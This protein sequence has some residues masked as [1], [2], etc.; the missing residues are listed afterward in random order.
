MV[1]G[2]RWGAWAAGAKG[3]GGLDRPAAARPLYLLLLIVVA[4]DLHDHAEYQIETS[5]P[6][7][8]VCPP[9]PP[10]SSP[11]SSAAAIATTHGTRRCRSGSARGSA[12]ASVITGSHNSTIRL[13]DLAA[14]K[15]ALTLTHSRAAAAAAEDDL[16][17]GGAQEMAIAYPGSLDSM[18]CI[19]A[20]DQR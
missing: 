9:P 14:G 20:A 17:F 3:G 12:V 15:T 7:P 10:L 13:W 5:R 1:G 2:R 18:P 8:L 11:T 4:V 16:E 6:P 19:C